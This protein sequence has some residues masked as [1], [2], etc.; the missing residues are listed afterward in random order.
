MC[1]EPQRF[2]EAQWP[3]EK[4]DKIFMFEYARSAYRLR[5][6]R[7]YKGPAVAAAIAI[8]KWG[9]RIKTWFDVFRYGKAASGKKKPRPEF[10]AILRA[11]INQ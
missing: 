3:W 8:H 10:V 7:Y 4:A 1:L 2:P 9:R 6:I 11:F 5:F